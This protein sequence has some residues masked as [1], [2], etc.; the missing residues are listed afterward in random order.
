M[1]RRIA[2]TLTAAL[3]LVGVLVLCACG[4]QAQPAT[5]TAQESG[6]VMPPQ[7]DAVA[8]TGRELIVRGQAAPLGRVVVSGAGDLAYAVGAD[9]EGRFELRVPRPAQDTL[10]R[11]E[12]RMGQAGF[13]APYRLLISAN[14]RAPI[15]L[16]TIGAPTRR[17]DG[18]GGLDAVDTDGRA[19]FVSGRA[20]AGSDVVI[21]GSAQRRAT[22]DAAGR[23]RLAG[24]GDGTT[25]LKIGG[26]TYAPQ[27]GGA[28][29]ADVLERAGAGWRIAWS[30]PGG[31]E[32]TTWF[33]DRMETIR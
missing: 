7:V 20:P 17:L 27:P 13:P 10:F 5:E 9:D 26:R 8:A 31:G 32:Q 2:S 19:A 11:V 29:A 16:L 22:A 12:A 4:E 21:D 6:W 25:P 18:A 1:K 14:P 33:P 30:S 15:A 3:S 28:S 23:W 24:S